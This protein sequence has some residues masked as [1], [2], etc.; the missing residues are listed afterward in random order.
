MKLLKFGHFS[1]INLTLSNFPSQWKKFRVQNVS[2]NKNITK[3]ISM[4]GN[5]LR[6][7]SVVKR[8]INNE[9][10]TELQSIKKFL[11]TSNIHTIPQEKIYE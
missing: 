1:I 5:R 11:N 2:K 8:S 7:Y 4:K 6:V 9:K 3:Y 10:I